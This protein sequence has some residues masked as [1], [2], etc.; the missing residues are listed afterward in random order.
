MRRNSVAATAI[1]GATAGV[2]GLTALTL[3]AGAE[4]PDLPA[5]A[6]E[7]LVASVMTAQPPAMAGTVRVNNNLGIPAI[8]ST[9]SSGELLSNGSSTVRLWADG[10]GRHRISLPS[11]GGG[12]TVVDDGTTVWKWNASERTVTKYRAE[13]R[14]ESAGQ[15]GSASSPHEEP[16]D[17]VATAQRMIDTLR[18]SS[19]I[20]VDGTAGVAGRDAYELVLTPK[21]TERTVLREVRIAVGAEKRLPLRVVVST[22]NS[23]DPALRVGFSKLETAPQDAELFRFSPPAGAQVQQAD[24]HDRRDTESGTHP[25]VR[26]VGE[27]WDS[28]LVTRVPQQTLQGRES[29]QD[30]EE[31]LPG[32]REAA[33][34]AGQRVSGPWGEGWFIST[35][36]GSALLTSDGRLAAGAVPQPVLTEALRGR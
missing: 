15:E 8:P 30:S 33:E 21:P 17:P 14:Q 26:T 7:K 28:V 12:T 4:D 23:E 13:A 35:G 9:E 3:P 6:P 18:Q 10:Q 5:I 27:G 16:E 36:A 19:R 2:L 31:R 20:S 29:G 11:E 22:E 25:Q 34:Q 32:L 1:A 24:K